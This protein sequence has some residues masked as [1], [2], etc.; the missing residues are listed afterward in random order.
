M[1]FLHGIVALLAFVVMMLAGMTAWLYMKQARLL[2]A[3]NTLAIAISTPPPPPPIPFEEVIQQPLAQADEPPQQEEDDR[4]SVHE[5]SDD[6]SSV[7]IS[8]APA[9]TPAEHHDED[10]D[11]GKKTIAEL[12]SLLSAK[13]I[14][15]NK[16]DKKPTLISLLQAT[17]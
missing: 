14:P 15:F 7:E 3:V 1:E 6:E 4:V 16:S 2:Q 11:F 13:G 17:Q 9:P 10:T 12:R 8:P 5:E